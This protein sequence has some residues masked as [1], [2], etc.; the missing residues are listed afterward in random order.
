MSNFFGYAIDPRGN[1]IGILLACIGGAWV[2]Q[3]IRKMM[4]ASLD[5]ILTSAI[6]LL[7]VGAI[8]YI[9]IMPIGS[10]LFTGM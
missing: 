5:M 7:I 3:Q 9:V 6:T 4:P 8:T 1:I 2:E 10:Y